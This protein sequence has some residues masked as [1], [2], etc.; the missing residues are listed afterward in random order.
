M[1]AVGSAGIRRHTCHCTGGESS[2]Y[3][4][5]TVAPFAECLVPGELYMAALEGKTLNRYE[6]RRLV[7]RGGMA[8]VY[9]GYDAHFQRKVAVKVFKREDEGMLLRFMREARLMASLNNP[10]LMPI[11][12]TGESQIDGFTR[13]YIVMSFMEC[14]TLRIPIC[15][16]TLTS[17]DV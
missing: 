7:G 9:E 1:G 10:H 5:C 4:G 16:T 15:L 13:Y 6:L 12:D 8:N 2:P 3:R 17:D 11:Y 14:R